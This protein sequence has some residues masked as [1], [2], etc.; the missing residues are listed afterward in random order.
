MPNNYRSGCGV[1]ID[2]AMI[3]DVPGY[4]WG[5]VPALSQA[6]VKYFSLG[7]NFMDG[8][9]CHRRLGRQAVLLARARRPSK[10]S[11]LGALQRLCAGASRRVGFKL[12]RDLPKR[13]A[14]LE[15]MGYPYDI[16][17]LRWNVGGDNGPPDATLPDVVRNW[18]AKHDYPKL[19]IATAGESFRAF[20]RRY[21]DKIPVFSGDFTPYWENGACSSARE[22]ALNRTAAER[23]VQAE[24]LRSMF[25]LRHYPAAEFDEA[26]RNVILYDEHTWGAFNSIDVPDK[27]F[28][29]D[30]WK[31]KQAFALDGDAQSRK[32]LASALADRGGPPIADAVDVFNTASWPRTDLVVLGKELSAAGDVVTAPDGKAV[33]SQR[34]ST[35]ELA[36]LGPRRAAV[37]RPAI[38]NLRRARPQPPAAPKP[39][40]HRSAARQCRFI[41]IPRPE[42]S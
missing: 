3:S 16:V 26:W 39:A 1:K 37:G 19:V 4:T 2:T 13:L 25:D 41:S 29:K 34:L 6:G 24:I 22:T 11:L 38:Y 36:F 27:P 14:Q 32:L 40:R 17:Q 5:T 21:A 33:P 7:I 28:V 23:L 12:D 31:I 15:Q 18:N 35:G 30:Q 20:E 10:D 9:W 42:P 8:A